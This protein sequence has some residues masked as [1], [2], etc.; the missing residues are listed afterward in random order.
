MSQDIKIKKM[1]SKIEVDGYDLV[2][3]CSELKDI[4]NHDEE[5]DRILNDLIN[6]KDDLVKTVN[7]LK[8]ELR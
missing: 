7:S 2:T 8:K 1:I 5:Y 6:V 3:L 4:L